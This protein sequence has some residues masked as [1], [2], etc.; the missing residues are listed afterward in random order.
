MK[1]KT[2]SDFANTLDARLQLP[3]V[4]PELFLNTATSPLHQPSP[5]AGRLEIQPCEI[6]QT[7]CPRNQAP[8]RS[9]IAASALM[10][11]GRPWFVLNPN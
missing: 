7:F 10:V 9:V 5:Q 2:E 1:P 6:V 11:N 3:G 4:R 8:F